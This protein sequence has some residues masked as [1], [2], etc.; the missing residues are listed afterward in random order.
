MFIMNMV[1]IHSITVYP[2]F[3]AGVG[4]EQKLVHLENVIFLCER[5]HIKIDSLENIYTWTVCTFEALLNL[6]DTKQ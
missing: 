6:C 3:H 2:M 1:C 4:L 5:F